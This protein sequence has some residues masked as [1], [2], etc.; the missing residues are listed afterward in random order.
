MVAG[1]LPFEDKNTAK[2]YQKIQ[3]P[4]YLMPSTFT[5]P[6]KDLMKKILIVDPQK[7]YNVQ[8][9]RAHPWYNLV[10]PQE[11]VGTLIGKTEIIVDETILDKVCKEYSVSPD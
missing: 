3:G 6:L 10:E 1:Y 2:L 7:R 8:D 9:I 11:K 5:E 4:D